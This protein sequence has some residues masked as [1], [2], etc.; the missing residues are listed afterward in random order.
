[1][2]IAIVLAGGTGS[3]INAGIP[4]QFIKVLGKPLMIYTLEIIEKHPMIDEIVLVCIE[5]YIPYA[6]QLC[7]EYGISKVGQI[8]PGGED[9]THSCING[10]ETLRSRCGN[11]DHVLIVVANRPF[12]A[13]REI[14]EAI[15]LCKLHGVAIP[16]RKCALCMFEVGNDRTH[17]KDYKRENLVQ[18]QSPWTFR[19][20]LFQDAL[21]RWQKGEL[22]PCENY[23]VAMFAAA[24]Y[25][26]YF[27]EGDPQNIKV[28]EKTD[29]MLMEQMLR[30]RAK[31]DAGA[32]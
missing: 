16:A 2:N 12:I 13:D 9:F 23:P 32:V 31:H 20:D 27:T 25:E 21:D 30:E 19:Y 15:E 1:M 8:V 28:T 18:I 24:G 17:S 26:V 29:I 7:E 6:H 22:P 10:M 4:K 11:D 5:S 14:E 3:R